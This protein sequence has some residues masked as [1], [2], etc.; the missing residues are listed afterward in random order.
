MHARHQAGR[1]ARSSG[2]EFA[3]TRRR[4]ALVLQA[5]MPRIADAVQS[6]LRAEGFIK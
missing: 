2:L 1:P 4:I 6:R 5:N 3:M